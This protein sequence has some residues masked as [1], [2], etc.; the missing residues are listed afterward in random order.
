MSKKKKNKQWQQQQ[1]RNKKNSEETSA[2]T[3]WR[4]AFLVSLQPDGDGHFIG[5]E[6]ECPKL[7]HSSHTI[8]VAIH[9]NTNAFYF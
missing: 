8:F 5:Q 6:Q 1:Q 2:L 3:S 7:R 4:P 9:D